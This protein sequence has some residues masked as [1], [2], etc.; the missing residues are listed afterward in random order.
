MFHALGCTCPRRR[1]LIGPSCWSGGR[2]VIIAP[3][4]GDAWALAKPRPDEVLI[5]AMSPADRCLPSSSSR[6]HRCAA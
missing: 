3:N 6:C 1:D 5:R 4:G 2:K